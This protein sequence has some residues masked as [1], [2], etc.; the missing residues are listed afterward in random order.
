MTYANDVI[1]SCEK[2]GAN[3]DCPLHLVN[4]GAMIILDSGGLNDVRTD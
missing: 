2:S 4:V 3:K 1:S